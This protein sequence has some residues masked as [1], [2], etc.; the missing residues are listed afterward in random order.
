MH[1]G[2]IYT[3]SLLILISLSYGPVSWLLLSEIFPDNIRGRAVSIA[4]VLN[5]GA[6][7]VVSLTFLTIKGPI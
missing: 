3:S 1:S 7:L 2:C 6:N 4:T 5:W